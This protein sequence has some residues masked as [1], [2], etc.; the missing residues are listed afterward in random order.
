MV[1]SE[2]GQG[3]HEEG[4]LALSKMVPDDSPLIFMSLYNQSP[5]VWAGPSALL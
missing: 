3:V 2:V 4:W 5:L 1:A